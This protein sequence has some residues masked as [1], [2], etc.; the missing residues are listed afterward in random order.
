[1]KSCNVRKNIEKTIES[2]I[3]KRNI[4]RVARPVER[5]YSTLFSIA[6][7]VNTLFQETIF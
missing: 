2:M 1:M 5:N 3:K 7:V 6:L 4:R